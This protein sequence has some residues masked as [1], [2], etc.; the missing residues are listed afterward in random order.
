MG[1]TAL[2]HKDATC[3]FY[4]TV[5]MCRGECN[6]CLFMYQCMSEIGCVFCNCTQECV[7]VCTLTFTVASL[8]HSGAFSWLLLPV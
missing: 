5:T 1:V 4:L 7:C 8:F 2:R 3:P 6:Q